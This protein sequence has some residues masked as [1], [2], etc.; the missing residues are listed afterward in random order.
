MKP[1]DWDRVLRTNLTGIYRICRAIVPSMVKARYGRIVNVSSV[2]AHV[3]NPGQVNYAA[4]KAGLEGLTQSLARELASRNV[5]VNCVA[6]GFIDTD[7]TR[8]LDDAAARALA[9]SGPAGSPRHAGRRGR[10][11]RV[12]RRARAPI[13]L[14]E[15]TLDV[16]GGMYM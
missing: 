9:G 15:S 14:P 2:V 7:M 3:G 11:G 13:T 5:T 6:P 16:N 4:A 12:P 10:R 1:E 8:A